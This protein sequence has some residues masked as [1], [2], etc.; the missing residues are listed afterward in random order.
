MS[1]DI[2]DIIEALRDFYSPDE[3]ERWLDSPNTLLGGRTPAMLIVEGR[4]DEVLRHI[5]QMCAGVY[6]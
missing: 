5:E 6:L 1:V 3:T 4:R 2:T